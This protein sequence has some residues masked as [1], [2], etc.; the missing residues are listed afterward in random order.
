MSLDIEKI[1]K[2]LRDFIKKEEL[3]NR[4]RVI[5]DTPESSYSVG[6]SH[7]VIECAE[8]TLDFIKRN[9]DLDVKNAKNASQR[10]KQLSLF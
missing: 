3:E 2:H 10:I 5:K 7:G 6:F 4:L 8:D 1:K 9:G